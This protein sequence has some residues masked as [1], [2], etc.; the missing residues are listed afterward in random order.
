VRAEVRAVFGRLEK[1]GW[2]AQFRW[3]FEAIL[4]IDSIVGG[5]FGGSGEVFQVLE[6]LPVVP[7]PAMVEMILERCEVTS[8]PIATLIVDRRVWAEVRHEM[9]VPLLL[10][11]FNEC[12][13]ITENFE[14]F[15]FRI[16]LNNR[17]N[18]G[19]VGTILKF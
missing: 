14:K 3:P 4:T 17:E 8:E 6:G 2:V 1:A 19:I 16:I 18:S 9:V 5:S 7:I 13:A 10:L 11:K 15:L 12:S